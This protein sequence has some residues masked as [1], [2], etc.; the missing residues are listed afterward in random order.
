MTNTNTVKDTLAPEEELE[1][2][3]T[4]IRAGTPKKPNR[5]PIGLS[6]KE[7]LNEEDDR[8]IVSVQP[9]KSYLRPPK[10]KIYNKLHPW[11][12]IEF[13][14]DEDMNQWALDFDAGRP[15]NQFVCALNLRT[16][17]ANMKP[18]TEDTDDTSEPKGVHKPQAAA[19]VWE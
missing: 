6:V 18:A 11:P 10:I 12:E 9:N 14:M 19:G 4:H 2:T 13:I 15:V 17:M 7:R 1:I 16:G 8:Y 5:C 3:D